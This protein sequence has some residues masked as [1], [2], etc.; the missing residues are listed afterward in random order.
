MIHDTHFDEMSFS[1]HSSD[2]YF[3]HS[4]AGKESVGRY[5]TKLSFWWGKNPRK[6]GHVRWPFGCCWNIVEK[7]LTFKIKEM[8]V[9]MHKD[10][11]KYDA[12]SIA[13]I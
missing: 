5:R 3:D 8:V 9:A 7:A 11:Q 4:C 12:T 13:D 6:H 1:S 10:L 2:R